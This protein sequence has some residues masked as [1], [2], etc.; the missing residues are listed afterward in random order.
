MCGALAASSSADDWLRLLRKFTA[1]F[2]HS[3]VC[4]M[5]VRGAVWKCVTESLIPKKSWR[6]AVLQFYTSQPPNRLCMEDC[7]LQI[8][9]QR[10][11]VCVCV[12]LG[13]TACHH[14]GIWTINILTTV[15]TAVKM[16]GCII[17]RNISY[18]YWCGF[19]CIFYVLC[20]I[21]TPSKSCS[22]N[23]SS[24]SSPEKVM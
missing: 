19:L 14:S 20:I 2:T 5:K 24:N 9:W 11:F 4:D 1:R 8:R 21:C 17:P 22:H 3:C 12:C 6:V 23:V 18:I 10:I 16:R 13:W 7:T 15:T